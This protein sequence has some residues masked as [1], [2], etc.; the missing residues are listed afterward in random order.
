MR[1]FSVT[2]P[3]KV[4]LIGPIF[5]TT[6]A[7]SSVSDFFSRL[8]QPGMQAFSTSGSLS[9]S[10]TFCDGRGD[11]LLAFDHQSHAGILPV[12]V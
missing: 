11:A 9:A 10:Q 2:S 3:V 6:V 8:W 5:S 1:F 4:A 7:A 12:E